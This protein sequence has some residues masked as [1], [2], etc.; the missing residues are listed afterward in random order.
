MPPIYLIASPIMTRRNPRIPPAMPSNFVPTILH[1]NI[2]SRQSPYHHSPT[3]LPNRKERNNRK[4][5]P[6]HRHRHKSNKNS[7]NLHKEQRNSIPNDKNQIIQVPIYS[8]QP[9]RTAPANPNNRLTLCSNRSY[10]N[11]DEP[12]EVMPLIYTDLNQVFYS[13]P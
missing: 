6:G 7:D 8:R 4:K 10:D 5:S 2:P 3:L 1:S 9:V 12:Y 11:D 13:I